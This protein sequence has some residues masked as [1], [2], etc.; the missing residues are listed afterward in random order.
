MRLQHPRVDEAIDDFADIGMLQPLWYHYTRL[1]RQ[2]ALKETDRSLLWRIRD[3]GIDNDDLQLAL[4]AQSLIAKQW[5]EDNVE[6]I[7]LGDLAITAGDTKQAEGIFHNILS[8]EPHNKAA[9]ERLKAIKTGETE[10][11]TILRG[12]GTSQARLKIRA[13]N[14][15]LKNSREIELLRQDIDMVMRTYKP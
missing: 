5:E 10:R 6:W 8:R 14:L 13:L 11:F 12:Y 4:A 9:L 15:E 1:V 2:R 3:A 7:I